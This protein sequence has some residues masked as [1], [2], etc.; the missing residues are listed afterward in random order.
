MR[1][2]FRIL[3]LRN[4]IRYVRDA[5]LW[6]LT[7]SF[8][9][10]SWNLPCYLSHNV[11]DRIDSARRSENMRRIRS[12]DTKPELIVRSLV[13]WMGYRFRLHRRDLPGCPDLVF[14]SLKKTVLVHGCFWHQHRRCIDGRLPKSRKSYWT[15]KLVKNQQRDRKN[16]VKL[17]KLGWKNLVVW[18][19]ETKNESKLRNRLE[20]FLLS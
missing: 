5:R 2:S 18:D 16:R 12:K 1:S 3:R 14:P 7:M 13:H 8:L 17:H 11:M 20:K 9:I 15:P 6:E 19:C 10:V 4:C